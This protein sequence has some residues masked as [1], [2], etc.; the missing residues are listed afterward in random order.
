VK[1]FLYQLQSQI[2]QGRKTKKTLLNG[3]SSQAPSGHPCI[4]LQAF[5]AWGLTKVLPKK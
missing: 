4:A 2:C 1:E 3:T 5:F